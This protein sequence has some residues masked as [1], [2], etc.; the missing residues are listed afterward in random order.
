MPERR[1]RLAIEIAI[2]TW[3]RGP[4]LARTLSRL[5][6]L[7]VPADVEWRVLV[8][9]NNST[10]TTGQV[11]ARHLRRLPMRSVF[12]PRP[13]LA[14]ARNRAVRES[15]AEYLVWTDDDVLVEADWLAGYAGAFRAHPE[16]GFFGGPV[17]PWFEGAPPRWLEQNWAL[18]EV[19]FAVRR[20]GTVE[21][22][23]DAARLPFGAN[24][25]VRLDV[26]RQFPYDPTLGRR[27]DS[28]VS[29]EETT[30]LKQLLAAGYEGWWVPGARVR[31]FIPRDRQSTGYL[32]RIFGGQGELQGR[33]LSTG[34][35][36]RLFGRPRWLLKQAVKAEARYR[37]SRA[38]AAPEVWVADLIEAART[39]GRLKAH[40]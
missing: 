15:Q 9:N 19:A 39:W 10:D 25:A 12:E 35:A 22:R 32:R 37:W 4:L 29:G 11:L 13:G 26:Q 31:H 34:A 23:F 6:S 40:S 21:F 3:N 16:A 14:N 1:R 38:T 27:P 33:A 8:V 36:P 5:E 20:F 18:A 24:C 7:R 17:E 2:C 28:S 30:L